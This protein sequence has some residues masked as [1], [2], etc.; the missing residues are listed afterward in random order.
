MSAEHTIYNA[1]AGTGKTYTLCEEI[2]AWINQGHAPEK[3]LATTF[4]RKAAAELKGRVQDATLKDFSS[5]RAI[6]LERAEK[7]ELAPIGTVHSVGLQ[8]VQRYALALGLAPDLQLISE[9]GRDRHLERLAAELPAGAW[10]GLATVA[11]RLSID[12]ADEQALKLLQE[13]RA[14]RI[15]DEAF[16]KQ[17]YESGEEL[18]FL[19]HPGEQALIAGGPE[20][21]HA[22][23]SKAIEEILQ[24]EDDYKNTKDA[25]SSLQTW[26][27]GRLHTWKLFVD[28]GDLK[29]SK[30]SGAH[31]CLEPLRELSE[32]VRLRKG[33]HDDTR[34]FMDLMGQKILA[35][36][37][38]WRRYKKERGLLDF[39]DLEVLFLRLLEEP[40]IQDD[41]RSDIEMVVVDEFQDTNPIQLEIFLR[42]Q[43]IARYG[44]WVGD[45]KQSIYRFRGADAQ[46]VSDAWSNVSKEDRKPLT[47]NWRSRQGLVDVVR[48][49]FLEIYGEEVALS[50]ERSPEP[51]CVER[52]LLQSKNIGQDNSA[53]A[54]GILELKGE[55]IG[56]GDIAILV[57]TN[58]RAVQIAD[59][60]ASHAIPAVLERPG[61]LKSRECAVALAGLRLVADRRDSLAAATL[62][63]LLQSTPEEETPSWLLDR[64]AEVAQLKENRKK[65]KEEGT[66]NRLEQSPWPGHPLLQ[67]FEGINPQA[68]EPAGTLL[69][70]I[71]A[72]DLVTRCAVWGE[73]ARRC[74]Q[75]EAMVA[76]AEQFQSQVRELGKAATLPGLIAHLEG[77]AD[78][79]EDKF[80]I[81]R[82]VD[83]VH[84]LTYHRA[85]GLEWPVVI[86]TQLE[87]GYEPRLWDPNV[88]GGNAKDGKPLE[89]RTLR[90]WP[91]PFGEKKK[92]HEL[93]ADALASETGRALAKDENEES[94][95]LLYVGTT[96]ARDRMILAHR[97]GKTDWFSQLPGADTLLPEETEPGEYPLEGVA[98]TLVVKSLSP[99]EE[100]EP[101]PTS[102]QWISESKSGEAE[103]LPR[104][105][106][107]SG[108]EPLERPPEI[109]METLGE[110]MGKSTGDAADL[111]SAVH[112]YY[113]ALPS[114][115]DAEDPR[116]IALA[117]NCLELWG[118]QDDLSAEALVETGTR[119]ENWI[120]TKW[121]EAK[122]HTE[123][124][125]SGERAEGGRWT[126]TIDLFLEA[127]PGEGI[128]I[129]HKT[130]MGVESKAAGHAAQYSGQLAAYEESLESAAVTVTQRWIHLP[131][132][133][134]AARLASQD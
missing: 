128:L 38:A 24:L 26:S 28:A 95:R 85:K 106:S 78:D 108:E 42:L 44:V 77:L 67:P 25:I 20:L 10:D 40:T 122:W 14:N 45:P 71:D 68:Q 114:L 18:C 12:K 92:G 98:T 87:K 50:A 13:K 131:L 16:R 39:T 22:A 66:P 46:L 89:G 94:L 53:L 105:R 49:L 116:R 57:R 34:L 8:L 47:K 91:T 99:R 70:I 54:S 52:W 17:M 130:W 2:V 93:D 11:R 19:L 100:E 117:Q 69:E 132:M 90:W 111:G 7:L 76:L 110:P 35:L 33:L 61:L 121:P 15:P 30:N 23:A 86:L 103:A 1:G 80:P 112:A 64:L 118:R 41:L 32:T 6:R 55:G 63:H 21:V 62:L 73:P 133:G 60:L 88:R 134:R 75:L 59:A 48:G 37:T 29:A 102:I 83:A 101:R 113:A 27:Q 31:A 9:E 4:T 96:R 126:G 51:R 43:K 56:F 65:Q 84:V 124:P 3:I 82:G 104:H 97:P 5:P 119:L 72:T 107:P 58:H 123:V 115:K 125:V 109:S 120:Q 81:P 79:T 129:D 74:A 127:K 36:Q